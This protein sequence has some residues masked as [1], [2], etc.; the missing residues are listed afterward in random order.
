MPLC[1]PR[2]HLRSPLAATAYLICVAT[3]VQI[4]T[5][6]Y[7][8]LTEK[9]EVA[10]LP[11]LILFKDGKEL[12]RIEGFLPGNQLVDRVRY[13]LQGAEVAA[14]AAGQA[15]AQGGACSPP[16]PPQ[17]QDACIPPAKDACTPPPRDACAPPSQE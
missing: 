7:P 10:G 9:F 3:I 8:A 4:D 13:F 15:S 17:V 16:P 6:K 12:N 14:A 2:P 11:T 1:L 5:D